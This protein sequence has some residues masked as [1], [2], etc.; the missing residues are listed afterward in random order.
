MINLYII[1]II[2]LFVFY[3]VVDYLLK[4]IILFIFYY[5]VDLKCT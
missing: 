4:W 1:M 5:V 2:F 3:L